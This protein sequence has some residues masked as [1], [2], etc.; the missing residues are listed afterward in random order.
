[1]GIT[2]KI[3]KKKKNRNFFR[4]I[5]LRFFEIY[6]MLPFFGKVST[7]KENQIDFYCK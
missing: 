7:E 3:E 2:G 6:Q 1:M 5:F 4:F